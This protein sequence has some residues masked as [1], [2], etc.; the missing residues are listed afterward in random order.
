MKFDFVIG[1][2]PY[3]ETLENTSDKPIYD[4]FM[5]A[6]F[7][8]SDRVEL[9]TP[10]RFLFD[11][12]KTPKNWNKKMLND[13]HFKVLHYEKD[14]KFFFPDTDINGGIAITYRDANKD[15]G[16]I[17]H[18]VVNEN[19]SNVMK[20]VT[21]DKNFE[22][23]KSIIYLQNKFNLDELYSDFPNAKEN[24][25]S[26]GRE[27][28]IVSSAFDNLSEVFKDH[29]ES[30][31]DVR[32]VGLVNKKREYKYINI[33]YLDKDSNMNRYKVLLSAADGSAG[34][35]GKPIPARIIGKT[36]IEECGVGYTQTFISIGAFDNLI[37]AEN[38]NKYLLTK[39]A[40]F[41]VGTV[42]AT[43]GL[44]IDVWRNVPIQNFTNVSDIDWSKTIKEID[45]QLYQK[46]SLNQGEISYI[47]KYIKEMS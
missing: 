2:P 36:S 29:A 23:I 18:F 28:R 47:E 10:G 1:N 34:T 19:I 16:A 40:R 32:I 25:S 5:D 24:I 11:A 46:Y 12:G 6:A 26:E 44:K 41:M 20:K 42:K 17:K 8:V 43:N 15:F 37:E 21:S 7:A 3:Q 31:S 9:I 27:K 14:P 33:K 22:S 30:E 45:Y 39:F 13:E 38:L 4:K 35:I